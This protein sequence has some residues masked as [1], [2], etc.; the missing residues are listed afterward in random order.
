MKHQ[1][2]L[3]IKDNKDLLYRILKIEETS[4]KRFTLKVKKSNDKTKIFIEA[5]D[6]TALKAIKTSMTK[7]TNL[8][9]EL[10]G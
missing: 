9:K 6:K 5:Q 2:V 3:E 8:Y 4:K 10:E 1:V 7:L